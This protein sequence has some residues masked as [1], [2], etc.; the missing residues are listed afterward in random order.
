M[1][2]NLIWTLKTRVKYAPKCTSFNEKFQK[3]L[4]REPAPLQTPAPSLVYRLLLVYSKILL[5]LF[6]CC[7]VW[8]MNMNCF[9]V[10]NG[11]QVMIDKTVYKAF[12]SKI[13]DHAIGMVKPYKHAWNAPKYTISNPHPPLGREQQQISVCTES[14]LLSALSYTTVIIFKI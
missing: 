13:S 2:L 12:T 9:S 1:Y 8:R 5:L 14:L 6:I 10:D 4:G 11:L 7:Q 3:F